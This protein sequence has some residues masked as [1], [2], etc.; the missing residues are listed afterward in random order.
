MVSVTDHR[1]VIGA[2]GA[3]LSILETDLEGSIFIHNSR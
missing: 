2:R 3:G 1:M